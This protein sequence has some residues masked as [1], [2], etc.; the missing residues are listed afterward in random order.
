[1]L[2]ESVGEVAAAI[3]A[4]D[5]IVWR[6]SGCSSFASMT[7]A[8]CGSSSADNHGNAPYASSLTRL[9]Q[10]DIRTS[11]APFGLPNGPNELRGSLPRSM[12]HP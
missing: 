11:T 3:N 5:S 10:A 2:S 1:M 9:N 12:P 7:P 6:C 8:N 4:S